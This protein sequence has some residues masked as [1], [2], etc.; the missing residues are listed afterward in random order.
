M[1]EPAA[2]FIVFLFCV[3][4]DMK[5]SYE[6]NQSPDLADAS[7]PVIFAEGVISTGQYETHPAFSPSGDTLY[8]LKCLPDANFYSICVSYRRNKAWSQP[9]VASFSGRYVD[10]DPFVTKDGNELYFVSNRPVNAGDPVKPDWDIW[11]C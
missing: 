9:E 11:K 8:F 6:P 4:C 5:H 3:S 7:E 2:I 10:A 1:R